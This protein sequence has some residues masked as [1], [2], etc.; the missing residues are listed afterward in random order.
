MATSV[1]RGH[2]RVQSSA[3]A[4]ST[5]HTK[6]EEE[7]SSEAEVEP[8]AMKK[9]IAKGKGAAKEK[10]VAKGKKPRYV[11]SYEHLCINY[12]EIG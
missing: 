7:A 2:T 3:L 4:T 5:K 12:P 6:S 11:T 1:P 9:A 10:G 8:Q